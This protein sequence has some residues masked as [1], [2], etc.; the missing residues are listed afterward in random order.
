[1]DTAHSA[2]GLDWAAASARA[3]RIGWARWAPLLL[4]L[5]IA[6][7][8]GALAGPDAGWD[9]RNY[10]LYNGM[11]L[12]HGRVGFDLAPAQLQSFYAPDLDALYA[13]ALRALNAHPALLDALLTLPHGLAAFLAWQVARGM[14]PAGTPGARG[15]AAAAVA[16]GIT[17]AGGLPTIASP[18]S[19][20]LPASCVL[21]ALLLVARPGGGPRSRLGAGVLAGIAVGL[22]LTAAP[23]A[24]GLA[25]AAG[26]TGVLRVPPSS[27]PGLTRP[28]APERPCADGRVAPRQDDGAGAVAGS[29]AKCV[30]ALAWFLSGAAAGAAVTG[31]WWW[32]WLWART[33]DPVF[34]YFNQIFHSPWATAAANTDTRFLPRDTV[35]ALAYPLFWAFTPSRL[36]SEL[37]ARDPR[38][39][40]G[41]LAVLAIGARAAWRRR[42]PAPGLVAPLAVWVVG[43]TLWEAQFSILRYLAT[44]ELLSGPLLLAALGPP[45]ARM[46]A[47]RSIPALA[48]L[49]AALA[50]MTVY[51][52]WGRAPAGPQAV[53]VRL[54]ALVPGSLVVL[55]DPSPMAYAAA[56][57]PRDVR[58]VG[59][60]NNLVRP[61]GG[62]ALDHAVAAAIVH[63]A[64]PLWGLAEDPKTANATL[65]AYGLA[66]APGCVRVRSNLDGNAIL[67]CPLTRTPASPVRRTGPSP[68]EPAHAASG[69][70]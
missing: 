26:M 20:M 47:R 70:R 56:F 36:V 2:A 62:T 58:F 33:G 13:L 7:L 17:G 28:S 40:L 55:L 14:L 41:W 29:A 57:A 19:E 65:R 54:P 42:W 11:A 39:L 15:L 61:G 9:L 44:L 6:A 27:W 45:L 51:P 32:L 50:A 69:R 60:N 37:P 23:Y 46:P 18:M 8:A 53:S 49:A 38:I 12:L 67:A 35:Q 5:T 22:K 1:M 48:A 31:G 66:R 16:I 24:V 63:Q 10:H 68:R 21:G 59:A 3:R 34:P 52:G 64:G 43:Y 25:V 4:C 30:R